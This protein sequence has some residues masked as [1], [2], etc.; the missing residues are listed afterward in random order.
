M[1]NPLQDGRLE[2]LA[3]VHPR[4]V[5]AATRIC[6][7]MDALGFRMMVTDGVR[8]TAK[9]QALYAQGRTAPGAIVTNTDGVIKKSN[10]QPK[11]DGL[12]HAV[13]MAFVVNGLP[14]WDPS[15]PW[16]LYGAMV[17]SLG[18]RW[19]GD[20]TSGLVDKPHMELLPET[21]GTVKA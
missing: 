8:T 21:P 6:L 13:D 16:F 10:H 1:G 18:L 9:Q 3:G 19:G 15:L 7:A 11:A 2:K 5:D 17:R 4:L 12:G 20:W 14:S